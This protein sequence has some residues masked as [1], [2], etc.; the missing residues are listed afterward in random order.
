MIDNTSANKCQNYPKKCNIP[1]FFQRNYGAIVAA[2][3]LEGYEDTTSAK[4]SLI[5]LGGD[6]GICAKGK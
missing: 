3:S 4:N 1:P 6:T 2:I 5:Q